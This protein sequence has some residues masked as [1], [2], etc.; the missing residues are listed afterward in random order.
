MTSCD[1]ER[2]TKH[3]TRRDLSRR[4]GRKIACTDLK[5]S[6]AG[7]GLGQR[8]SAVSPIAREHRYSVNGAAAR[9]ELAMRRTSG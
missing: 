3:F 9:A 8:D 7:R 6:R 5:S 4:I 2:L 1:S